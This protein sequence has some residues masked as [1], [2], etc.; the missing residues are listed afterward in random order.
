MER[1]QVVFIA[2]F[3][4][5]GRLTRHTLSYVSQLQF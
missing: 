5:I 1:L 2:E 4:G 3:D